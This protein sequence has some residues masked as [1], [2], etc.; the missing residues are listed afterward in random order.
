M[1]RKLKCAASFALAMLLVLGLFTAEMFDFGQTAEAADYTVTVNA[2]GYFTIQCIDNGKVL[3]VYGS[4]AKNVNVTLYEYDATT[5]VIWQAAPLGNNTF[6]FKPKCAPNHRL[7]IWGYHAG[8]GCNVTSYSATH[9]PT[10]TWI[11]RFNEKLGAYAILSKDDPNYALTSDGSKNGSNICIRRYDENNRKQHWVSDMFSVNTN[12]STAAAAGTWLWPCGTRSLSCQFGDTYYHSSW[13]HRGIDIRAYY[14]NVFASRSGVF[15]QMDYN[16]SRGYW[17]V[18]DHLDGTYSA[19]QHLNRYYVT[20]GTY[21]EQGKVIAQSGASGQG[22]GP[23]LHFEIMNLGKSGLAKS[24][25]NYFNQFSKY[26]NTNPVQPMTAGFRL[27]NGTYVSTFSDS[28]GINY[29][30]K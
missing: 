30:F 3:N 24:Y 17:G 29:K 10:Q 26:V 4:S 25:G 2:D 9:S 7:N 11:V 15:Y 8:E 22:T 13:T 12:T 23:H 1:K 27:N 28:K 19:Y 6:A 14:E 18:I 21:V 16:S 5:G 20:S